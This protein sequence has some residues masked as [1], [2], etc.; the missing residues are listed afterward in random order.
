MYKKI[1]SIL[2]N[3]LSVQNIVLL[4]SGNTAILDALKIA[5]QK[6]KKKVIIQDQ[7]GWLTYGQYTKKLGM[8]LV[9][10][11]T[12]YG[13]VNKTALLDVLDKDS[14]FLVNSMPG[15][16][17]FM[18]MELLYDQ[19]NKRG[20][21]VINDVT[22]S[23]DN[24][25]SLY[26]DIYVGSFG[27]WKPLNVG[28]GGFLATKA[29]SSTLEIFETQYASDLLAKL[30]N[31]SQ[32]C[33]K[34]Q[35]KAETVKRELQKYEIVHRGFKGFNVIVKFINTNDKPDLIEYCEGHILPFT[36][37]PRYIRITESAI[38]IEI[39]RL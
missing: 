38:S 12:D 20:C 5:K 27:K 25:E 6:G 21:L 16:H 39:K 37:C 29:K 35:K 10:V 4:P 13:F 17:A 3:R 14:V 18:N 1:K 11:K 30:Q 34:L 8:E 24:R 9:L 28:Y 22:G 36:L 26:G 33:L 23:L 31:L 32:R 7:G 19:C 15:Y 2:G